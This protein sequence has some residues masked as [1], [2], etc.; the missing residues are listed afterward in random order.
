MELSY[1]HG[2]STTPL[3]GETIGANLERTGGR[4]PDAEVLV[5]RHQGLRYTYAAFDE[6]VNVVARGLLDLGLEAGDRIG[7]W[8]P[9]NAEWALVQYATAKVGV[10]LVNINPAY[11]T[12]ELEYALNQSGCRTLVA[13]P[14]FKTS[15]YKA[16]VDEVKPQLAALERTIYIGSPEWD[17]LLS[18][19]ETVPIDRLRDRMARLEVDDAIN[20]PYTSGTP[21]LPKGATLSHHNILNN[22]YFIG[23]Y[24]R[25]TQRYPV[26]V[27]L[28]I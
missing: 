26:C 28:P 4:V 16:M 2:A 8:S 12:S 6:A 24:C 15:D 9:N 10:I 14:S 17:A 22:G 13:A 20:I 27:P 25:Y 21:G 19:G 23:E 7:I 1:A 5:S 11:P 3:V 18:A